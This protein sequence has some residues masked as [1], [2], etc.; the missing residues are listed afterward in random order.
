MSSLGYM[1]GGAL[2]GTMAGIAQHNIV[3]KQDATTGDKVGL[4]A[5]S[6]AGLGITALAAKTI[7]AGPDK[8]LMG[9]FSAVFAAS[10][11]G[12]GIGSIDS[13]PPNT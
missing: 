6:A 13:H 3:K 10:L 4:P 12:T 9:V 1:A 5:L 2:V 11:I 7:A 8:R